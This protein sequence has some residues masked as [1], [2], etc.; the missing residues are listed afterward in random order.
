M[1]PANH[2]P[3]WLAVFRQSACH[4]PGRRM[5]FGRQSIGGA[6]C[7]HIVGQGARLLVHVGT[8]GNQPQST[9]LTSAGNAP[10]PARYRPIAPRRRPGRARPPSN[11]HSIAIGGQG[12]GQGYHDCFS[13]GWDHRCCGR[14]AV[15]R[16]PKPTPAAQH[17]CSCSHR[18]MQLPLGGGKITGQNQ[19]HGL[20]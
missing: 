14:C 16:Q 15:F 17:R 9:S 10:H 7:A 2:R 5:I 8:G 3:Y 11:R 18:G 20:N 1:H 12:T 19:T 4:A 13:L 6:R